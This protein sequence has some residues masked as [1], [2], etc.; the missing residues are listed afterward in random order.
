[1]KKKAPKPKAASKKT[2]PAA[3]TLEIEFSGDPAAFRGSKRK[4][5]RR[6]GGKLIPLEDPSWIT[7][8]KHASWI[9]KLIAGMLTWDFDVTCSE[10]GRPDW[11]STLKK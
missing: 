11:S 10:C 8:L 5:C 2:A 9:T 7:K 4:F 3:Q 6:C 1:M